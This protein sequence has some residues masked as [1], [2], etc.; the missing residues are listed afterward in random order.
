[1]NI[2]WI[3]LGL[4]LMI[5]MSLCACDK[6][7]E[8]HHKAKEEMQ[9]DSQLLKVDMDLAMLEMDLR[10]SQTVDCMISGSMKNLESKNKIIEE[11]KTSAANDCAI[12]NA[13]VNSTKDVFTKLKSEGRVGY[14]LYLF[15]VFK[16]EGE[17][18]KE[19]RAGVFSSLEQCTELEKQVHDMGV[20]TSKCKEWK[21]L[22]KPL[23]DLSSVTK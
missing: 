1:M 3:R 7:T 17:T 22:L 8:K 12:S 15:T 5:F 19:Q 18:N 11:M 2:H 6:P 21:S 9:I 4:V 14:P 20:P 10:T 13:L 23:D 16:S